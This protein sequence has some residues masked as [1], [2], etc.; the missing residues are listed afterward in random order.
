MIARALNA[1]G[2]TTPGYGH[3]WTARTVSRV[4]AAGHRTVESGGSGLA[5]LTF[6]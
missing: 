5:K 6:H 1:R 4:Q 2:L 3:P